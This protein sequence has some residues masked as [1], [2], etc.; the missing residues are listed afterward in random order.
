MDI[1]GA[2][3]SAVHRAGSEAGY[4]VTLLQARGPGAVLTPPHKLVGVLRDL[5]A[6]GPAGAA[7]SFA[8]SGFGD[9]PAIIDET[10]SLT[11]ADLD[12]RS[13]ALANALRERGF[14]ARQGLGILCR[15]H[16]GLFESILAGVKLGAKTLLLN[17]DF[18]GPQLADV[19]AREAVQALICDEEFTAVADAV[20]PS[21]DRYVAWTDSDPGDGS[22]TS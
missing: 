18:A 11:F 7:V 20:D 22:L 15:N 5:E 10:G 19:C 3:R 4:A 12:R 8:A 9:R 16:R 1:L 13:N 14:T 6:Y 21:V 17:T 2:A